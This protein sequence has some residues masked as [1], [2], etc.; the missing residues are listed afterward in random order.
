M[1]EHNDLQQQAEDMVINRASRPA[2]LAHQSSSQP[3]GS[4][5][6]SGE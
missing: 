4:T 2:S 6:A 1:G 5:S 3:D